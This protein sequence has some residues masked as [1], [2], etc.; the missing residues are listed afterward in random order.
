MF[1]VSAKI[2]ADYL[3]MYLNDITGLKNIDIDFNGL[4]KT[5]LFKP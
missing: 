2:K 1:S 5:V 4:N 3:W